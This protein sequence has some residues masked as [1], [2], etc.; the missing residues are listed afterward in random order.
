M[1]L[2]HGVFGLLHAYNWFRSG[3]LVF[4]FC[5]RG[6]VM[7]GLFISVVSL[8]YVLFVLAQRW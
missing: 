6:A 4:A 5:R 1:A 3:N 8:L 2:L 7:H